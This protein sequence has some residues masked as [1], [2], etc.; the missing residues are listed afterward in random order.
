MVK[1][2]KKVDEKEEEDVCRRAT[3]LDEQ[4]AEQS[5]A[6]KKREEEDQVPMII[7][8]VRALFER[9]TLIWREVS[10]KKEMLCIG[11]PLANCWP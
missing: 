11:N 5:V 2:K 7:D 10:R 6:I 4:L 1:K 9:K 8:R 3:K